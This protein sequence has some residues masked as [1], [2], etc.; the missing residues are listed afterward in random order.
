MGNF[1]A[2]SFLPFFS[3]FVLYAHQ[4]ILTFPRCWITRASNL[5]FRAILMKFVWEIRKI[6]DGFV[7]F[8]FFFFILFLREEKYRN[9]VF[10]ST[11]INEKKRIMGFTRFKWIKF[12]AKFLLEN[13][14]GESC[15]KKVLTRSIGFWNFDEYRGIFFIKN[16]VTYI[17]FERWTKCRS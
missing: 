2:F 6:M 10:D 14:E 8:F 3:T 7:L 11:S 17:G 4:E 9:N 13:R 16:K 1:L 5:L 12:Q 15:N